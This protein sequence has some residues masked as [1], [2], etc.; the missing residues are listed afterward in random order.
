MFLTTFHIL[1]AVFIFPLTWASKDSW[2]SMVTPKYFSSSIV[3]SVYSLF[4]CVMLYFL[5]MFRIFDFPIDICLHF[6]G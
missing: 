3:D 5:G 1:V 4:S 2:G 6:S